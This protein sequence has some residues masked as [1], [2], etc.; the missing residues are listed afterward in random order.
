MAEKT[1]LYKNKKA[2]FKYEFIERLTAGIVLLGTEIKSIRD[3][4]IN[5]SD[6]FCVFKGSELWVT[7]IHIA[8]YVLGTCN[9]HEPKRDRKLLLNRRELNKLQKKVA[10]KGLT[11]VPIGLLLNEKGIAKLEI[12]LAKGK[13][14][15]DKR[16]DIKTRDSK[17]DMERSNK[18]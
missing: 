1:I 6:S 3:G 15:H 14:M 8:E 2:Y 18:Y 13:K 17:R 11:I 12:A 10:E 16:E 4:K 5:F 7:G 9:N